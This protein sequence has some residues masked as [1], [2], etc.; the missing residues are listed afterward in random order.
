[1]RGRPACAGAGGVRA[2]AATGH[3]RHP[4]PPPG[5]VVV[6]F[7]DEETS[8]RRQLQRARIANVHNRRVRDAGTGE[9]Q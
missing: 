7:V 4:D 2:A 6:L 9:F 5:Q 1:M 8:I 3:L